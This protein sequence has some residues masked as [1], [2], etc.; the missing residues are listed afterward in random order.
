MVVQVDGREV[1]WAKSLEGTRRSGRRRGMRWA[2][3]W[4]DDQRSR[5]NEAAKDVR[6]PSCCGRRMEKGSAG[7]HGARLGWATADSADV[8]SLPDVRTTSPDA[9]VGQRVCQLATVEH[10]TR[11]PQ[12]MFDQHKMADRRRHDRIDRQTTGGPAA[13]Q[14]RHALER[15]QCPGRHHPESQ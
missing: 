7:D 3:R 1:Q 4:A 14:P 8:V 11:L 10:F 12:W 6:H 9:T 13:A 15:A 2:K 5:M